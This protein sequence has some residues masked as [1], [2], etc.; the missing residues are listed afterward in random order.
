MVSDQFR[1]H[2]VNV[3]RYIYCV[4]FTKT[5][6][7][8]R[9]KYPCGHIIGSKSEYY[10]SLIHLTRVIQSAHP[11]TEF[12]YS[13]VSSTVNFFL[14]LYIQIHTHFIWMHKKWKSWYGNGIVMRFVDANTWNGDNFLGFNSMIMFCEYKV[15]YNIRLTFGWPILNFHN[16]CNMHIEKPLH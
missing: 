14:L 16:E 9:L 8:S 15:V 7:I 4:N 6:E 13:N 12:I 2:L 3:L 5:M 11:I 10:P 1:G